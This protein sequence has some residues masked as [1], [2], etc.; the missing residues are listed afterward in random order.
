MATIYKCDACGVA[1]DDPYN[2]N[3]REFYVGMPFDLEGTFSCFATRTQVVDLC[4]ECFR[5]LRLIAENLGRSK[6]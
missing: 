3:M 1:M 4:E 2:A 6:A 5:G